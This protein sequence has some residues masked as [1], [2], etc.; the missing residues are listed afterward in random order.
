M[1]LSIIVPAYN[2]AGVIERCLNSLVDQTFDD[3][4]VIIVNDGSTDNT[5]DVIS[6]FVDSNITTGRRITVINQENQGVSVARNKGIEVASGEYLLFVDADDFI[7]T[8]SLKKIWEYIANAEDK[9]DFAICNM[10]K[11][12]INGISEEIASYE[13]S[14]SSNVAKF[15]YRLYTNSLVFGVPWGKIY[16]RSVI[17]DNNLRFN[18]EFVINEDL[19][20]NLQFARYCKSVMTIPVMYY[21]YI[22]AIGGSTLKFMGEKTEQNNEG[23]RRALIEYFVEYC[24]CPEMQHEIYRRIA[25]EY[26]FKIYA[27]YRRRDV[28]DRQYWAVKIWEMAQRNDP[29]FSHQFHRGIPLITGILGRHS[30]F[31]MDKFLRFVFAVERHKLNL[32]K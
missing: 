29:G 15:Y 30:K 27:I 21:N 20:F 14:I 24:N 11:T 26:L 4:E 31:L 32:T 16:R 1:K 6:K 3:Y 22:H 23:V 17:I 9:P 2:A 19:L 8:D 7:E 5:M 18:L 12:S 28:H 13:F 25:F 10:M